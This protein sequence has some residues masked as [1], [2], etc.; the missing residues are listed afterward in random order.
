MFAWRAGLLIAGVDEAGR[1]PLAGPVTAA[2]VILDPA[3]PIAGLD[4]SKKLSEK[5][6]DALEPL[7]R[8]RALAFCVAHAAVHEI[9]EINILQATLLAMRRAVAGL[10]TAA[11]AVVVDGNRVT[12]FG[13]PAEAVVG[14]DARV[15]S[16]SAA[17]IL[18]KVARDREMTALDAQF[19]GYGFAQHKGYGT[20][21]H[22]A[23]LAKLGAT[24]HHRRSFAPVAQQIALL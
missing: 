21:A 2:A 3:R 23:A 5:K 13:V 10:A 4:D 15:P 12:A 8:E 20:A 11:Q 9:D 7:I 14:G 19:P 18:A 17:S 16:I 1:G 24:P 6:R 22:L